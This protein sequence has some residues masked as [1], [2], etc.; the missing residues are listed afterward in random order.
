MRNLTLVAAAIGSLLAATAAVAVDVAGV[1]ED[2]KV[3]RRVAEVSRGDLPRDVLR[4]LATRNVDELRG[5]R[6]DGTFE[7]A[8]Y[9][10]V[11][12]ARSQ[13]RFTIKRQ[14][15]EEALVENTMKGDLIY[16]IILDV[17]SRR[18]LVA[19]NRSVFVERVEA[20]YTALGGGTKSV[21]MPVGEWIEPGRERQVNLPDIARNATVAVYSR[22][23]NEDGTASLDVALLQA[24]LVD[25]ATSPYAAAVRSA[26]E[27]LKTIE[28]NDASGTR[29]LAG[30]MI[31]DLERRV[32]RLA[33]VTGGAP[34]APDEAAPII[35]PGM[36]DRPAASVQQNPP[37]VDMYLE[38]QRIED[39]LTGTESERREGLDRLHQLVRKLRPRQGIE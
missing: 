16:R 26:K 27:L 9:E 20:T 39:L 30:S 25:D 5:R 4:T 12:A 28:K 23:N 29:R 32:T 38:L 2:A 11:E 15:E 6:D 1:Y 36:P 22:G 7:Y 8:H 17:P 19:R 21:V 31:A 33:P 35:M 34:P 24:S 13:E 14:K 37:D 3:I 10:P 18:M